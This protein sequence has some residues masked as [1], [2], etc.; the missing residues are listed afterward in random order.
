MTTSLHRFRQAQLHA[1]A[2]PLGL[3]HALL[4]T[5]AFAQ[6]QTPTAPTQAATADPAPDATPPDAVV[7]G[8]LFHNASTT[9][10]S[11]LTVVTAAAL[12]RRGIN[13]AADAINQIPANTAGSMNKS[14]NSFTFATGATAVSLRGL[15]TGN[16]RTLIDGLRSAPYPLA[17]AGHR[18]FVDLNTLPGAIID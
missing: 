6:D 9:T 14:W 18:N 15:T 5:P 12:A 1:S 8:T 11:P 10:A 3:A 2:A 7:T 17:D 16:T 4:A 13:T